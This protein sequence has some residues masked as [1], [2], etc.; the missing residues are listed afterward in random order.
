MYNTC[1]EDLKKIEMVLQQRSD[2]LLQAF[3]TND[4]ELNTD[5]LKFSLSIILDDAHG[6]VQSMLDACP[7]LSLLSYNRVVM[8]LKTWMLGPH[9]AMDFV[10]EC[11]HALFQGV[12]TLNVAMH[13]VQRLYMCTG[14]TSHDNVE[15]FIF[16]EQIPLNLPLDDFIKRFNHQMRAAIMMSC[17]SLVMHRINCLQALLTDCA[18]HV[19]TAN[20]ASVF[21]QRLSHL[22]S[23]FSDSLPNMS[24]LL[25]SAASF[26][27]DAWTALGH[28]TGAMII[29]R[30]DLSIEKSAFAKAWRAS[31][32][33]LLKNCNDNVVQLQDMLVAEK[34]L[35]RIRG[36]KAKALLSSLL[37]QEVS[38]L[39]IVEEL[40]AC[41]SLES[42]TELWA[43]RYQLRF[44]YTK[45]D[46]YRLSP[47]EIS[48]GSISIPHGMEYTGG[49]IRVVPDTQ[50]E[51]ALQK[52]LSSAL[53][54]R[55]SVFISYDNPQS[56]FESQGTPHRLHF[57]QLE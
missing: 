13:V 17:D 22:I 34:A 12:G 20:I 45:S 50:L 9:A 57:F 8:L 16:G 36:V 42:A 40:L 2:N 56:L 18:A 41:K 46:R 1:T 6:S 49:Y 27:E 37:L 48:L 39:R 55:G 54:M 38:F 24:Y 43:G 21:E 33:T 3:A 10:S 35:P 19:V 28:P 5:N 23:M 47:V 7:R 11:F 26:A 53:S 52:V 32:A 25:M 31:L 14:F 51:S 4:S 44:Q 29:A 15:T 30:N